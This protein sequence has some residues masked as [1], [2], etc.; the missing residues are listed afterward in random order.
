MGYGSH[1]LTGRADARP[2]IRRLFAA[3]LAAFIAVALAIALFSGTSEAGAQAATVSAGEP[4]APVEATIRRDAHGI[5]HILADDYAGLG[6]GYGYAFAEDNICT[7]AESYVTVGAQRSRFF[8]P[9]G[10]Y[11]QRGNGF[12]ANNLNSDFFYQRIIDEGI[13]E[14]LLSKEPP[15]GP[16]DE[17][18]A[19]VRGYVAGYNK[20]LTE[21]GVENLSDPRCRGAEWVRPITEIDAF[22]RFYQLTLLASQSVAIDGIG[23]AQPPAGDAG[24]PPSPDAVTEGLSEAIANGTLG[25]LGSNAYGLG[26]EATA[27]GRGMVL[28]NPHFPWDGP[29]RFYQSHLTIPGEVNVSGMSLYGVPLILIGHT[30]NLAWSHTVSTAFRFT[31]FEEALVPGSPTTYIYDG[32][33]RQ[34][35]RDTVTVEVGPGDQR[36]RTLYST[37]HGPVFNRL[38][39]VDL[40]WIQGKAFTMGDVNAENF[41]AFNHFFFT[42]QA[43]SVRELDQIERTY[44]GIPWVNTIAADSSGESYYADIGA[45]PNVPDEKAVACGT[46]VGAATFAALRLPVLNGAA[47]ACE[48]TVD[49]DAAAPGIF[50]DTDEP[51]LFRDDYVTNSN[52]SYWLS[53]PEE[54]LEGFDRI[55]G[56]ERTARMLRTRLGLR[57]VQQRL[58]GTDGL[59]GTGFTADQ[60]QTVAFNNRVYS[61]EL[62]QDGVV[63][64]CE[65]APDGKLMS[66]PAPN[67]DK[68]EQSRPPQE[69]DVSE[70]CPILAAWDRH[71]DLDSNGAVLFRRFA[72]RAAASIRGVFA[73]PTVF[74]M[75]FNPE[76]PVNTPSGLNVANPKVQQAL[77]D[78]VLELRNAGIPLDAPLRGWQYEKRGEERI[79][80]HGGPHGTGV[81]NVI[82]AP[83]VSSGS[84]KGFPN[85]IHGS[86]Y[87]GVTSFTDGCPDDR[88]ILTYSQ[89]ENPNSPYFADQTRMYSEKQW[90]NPPYCEDEIASEPGMTITMIEGC[91]PPGCPEPTDTDG[92]GI[93]DDVDQCPTE[94]G[95][96]ENNGCPDPTPTDS[97]EDGV[98]DDADECPT[99]AGTVENNGCPEV[100]PTDSD[101][102]G[103]P[104]TEDRCPQE[105]GPAENDGCPVSTG[106]PAPQGGGQGS[107][108]PAA[109]G[110]AQPT[111]KAK[112]KSCKAKRASKKR[113][114]CKR[115]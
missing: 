23:S 39:T 93:T 18:R 30:D 95:T 98:P 50:D 56:D 72:T 49:P 59:S 96:P 32:Q 113:K 5:P 84:E 1:D 51:S 89:S 80:I 114:R 41:R 69:V 2:R 94:A 8:G 91:L 78:A 52:D 66:S 79:P 65:N 60:L 17:I 58:D 105:P 90:V 107:S 81:F 102:D 68:P 71:D 83:F 10:R 46:E 61:G 100:T 74:T 76:D 37:H 6:F 55:I 14:E 20:Y 88:S 16:V 45:I 27:N 38:S 24:P 33:P 70:A 115:R 34:M 28:A 63:Q 110:V 35:E 42:N 108:S 111:P 92:D 104:D 86:S 73:D 106:T 48:W 44:Q 21:T 7:I 67:T 53:N 15:H 103:V 29:E 75:P 77:A 26:K 54:P 4:G 36:T 99:E 12:S 57:L 109:P 11:E 13:V 87:V 22:R 82:T 9:D 47:S 112:Q 43:Q 64:L 25:G 85:V 19:G 3:T 101:G 62:W 31:P 40:P 97:D